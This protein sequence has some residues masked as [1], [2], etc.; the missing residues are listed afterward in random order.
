MSNMRQLADLVSA[1]RWVRRSL[2][3]SSCFRLW[4]SSTLVF[5]L[6][7]KIRGGALVS[8][9]LNT[10]VLQLQRE[11]AVRPFRVGGTV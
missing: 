8:R 2:L 6:K 11:S 1:S 5:N 10:L 7:F 4:Q 3:S 9:G